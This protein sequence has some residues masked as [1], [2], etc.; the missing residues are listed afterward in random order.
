MIVIA[1]TSPIC[2]LI[3]IEQITLLKR[4]FKQVTIPQAVFNELR[5]S[6]APAEVKNWSNT[7]P[8]WLQVQAAKSTSN[9]ALQHLHPGE[10]EAISLALQLN[11]NLVILD[12]KAARQ[13]AQALGFRITGLLGILD[14]AASRDLIDLPTAIA[15]LRQ[16]NFRVSS[17]LLESLLHKYGDRDPS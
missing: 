2:Y 9:P 3:L 1:D 15:R 16:T 12:E 5:A 6:S 10:R 13:A 4:L 8:A 11:A 17:Q 7:I 14:L